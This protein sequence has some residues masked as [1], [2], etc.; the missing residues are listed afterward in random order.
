MYA[1]TGGK[2]SESNE[3]FF[4]TYYTALVRNLRGVVIYDPDDT[5]YRD[6]VKWLTSR[7]K[8]QNLD[9]PP[10]FK[11]DRG[12]LEIKANGKPFRILYYSYRKN[13]NSSYSTSYLWN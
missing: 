7:F 1:G 5:E 3:Y 9:I 8:Y 6:I 11:K 2:D 12:F 13:K 10:L 4:F